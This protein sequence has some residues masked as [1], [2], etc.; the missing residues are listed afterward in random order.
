MTA[1]TPTHQKPTNAQV[2][3]T[4]WAMVRKELTVLSRY[5]V[6]FI[7]SFVQIFIIVAI[8]TLAGLTFSETGQAS[9]AT[10]GVVVYGFVMFMFVSD[11][12]WTIGFNVRHEQVQGTLEQLYLSPASKFASL[13]ARVA[14]LLIWTSLLSLTS[15]LIMR[16]MLGSLP[17]NNLGLALGLLAFILSGTFGIGF[18]FAALTLR[19]KEA[20]NSLVNM[21]QFVFMILGACFFPF[22]ALPEWMRWISRLIPTAYGVDIFRSTL[23]GYP[24]GFP[25]LAPVNVEIVIVVVFGLVMPVL[26]YWL[27]RGAERHAREKGSLGEF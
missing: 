11:T 20:A 3:S 9:E 4:F 19:V 6:D 2:F 18:A 12:L 1:I 27:F 15:A 21:F 8:F 26:G 5:P 16:A 7:A 10:S 14:H 25:E 13:I 17:V 24:A 23:M 22:G